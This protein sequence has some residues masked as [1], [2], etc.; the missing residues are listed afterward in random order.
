MIPRLHPRATVAPTVRAWLDALDRA[1][2]AGEIDDAYGTRIALATDNSIYERVPQAALFPRGADD[3]LLALRLLGEERF[4]GVTMAPRGAGTGTN[5]QSLT[6]GVV[7][8]CSRHMD[9]IGPV[10]VDP[11]GGGGSVRVGPGAV[12]DRV[13][14]QVRPSG[15]HFGPMVSTSNRATLGGMIANDSAGKGSLVHGKTSDHLRSLRI[16]L[17]GGA[18]L[19]LRRLSFEELDEVAAR[20]D[21]TGRL[22]RAVDAVLRAERDEI[23]RRWPRLTRFVTGYNLAM[24]RDDSARIFDLARIVAGSE[25]TLAVVLEAELDLEPLPAARGL[26]AVGYPTLE[27]AASAA[28]PLAAARPSAIEVMDETLLDLARTD[29]SWLEAGEVLERCGAG[30]RALVLV[31]FTGAEAGDVAVRIAAAESILAALRESGSAA[32]PTGFARAEGADVVAALWALRKRSVGLLGNVPGPRKPVPFVEDCAVPPERLPEFVR[33]YRAMLDEAGLRYGIFGHV[34]AG[35]VHVR[36]ALDMTDP[37]D[38]ARIAPITDAVAGLAREMGG[39]LWGEHGKGVRGAYNEHFLGPRLAGAMERIKSA[40]DPRNQLNPGKIAA[41]S[42]G[43]AALLSIDG[44]FRGT[45]DR[46]I[47]RGDRAAFHDALRCNGNGACLTADPD[48]TMCPSARRTRD[49]VHSPKGRAAMMREWLRLLGDAGVPAIAETR[50]AALPRRAAA[51]IGRALGVRDFSHEVAEAMRGC[52]ACKG[53]SGRCPVKVD[54]PTLRAE[55]LDRYHGRYLRPLRDRLVADLER[56]L[57]RAA[58]MPALANLLIASAPARGLAAW[59]VGLVDAPPLARPTLVRRL[60]ARG[61]ALLDEAA[62]AAAP[63]AERRA[64]VVI[65]PDAFTWFYAPEIVLAARAVLAAIGRRPAIPRF[66]PTGKPEHVIGC[67]DRFRRT[68]ALAAPRLERLAATGATLMAIDPAVT[69]F[70][71]DEYPKLLGA[72]RTRF[73]VLAPEELLDAPEARAAL[74]APREDSS[75]PP[76]AFALFGHCT[77]RATAPATSGQW[78]RA[79]AAAGLELATPEVGCCGM[80][81]AWGHERRNVADS[82][83][84]WES[85]WGRRIGPDPAALDEAEPLATGSSCRE[86]AER[87]AG[88]RLRHP[89]EVLAERLGGA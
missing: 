83:G 49:R 50:R 16:G 34:D 8:D 60:D 14:A 1:G 10:A 76:G 13:N 15:L 79:F 24:A 31:E 26:L 22:H 67:F 64:T 85:S 59:T 63:E 70:L 69:L 87:C 21:A 2:F 52:L 62:L 19:E 53:C 29:A 28:G 75:A 66:F 80:C 47:D 32:A 81:G 55:F 78:R 44:A 38:A 30:M 33:R 11:G 54:V 3:V 48:E 46:R 45:E 25:G 65:V 4:A 82:R 72:E 20:D 7:L 73:R 37:E 43:R 77:A 42:G 23:E 12:L 89:L 74:A 57:P 41:P 61:V 17:V 39:V 88:R 40:F 84:I 35:C 36:P 18:A 5:A 51:T 58:R 6:D 86:Q 71:R 56:M 9:G 27:A 68:A